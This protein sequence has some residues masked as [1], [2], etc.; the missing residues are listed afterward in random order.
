MNSGGGLR[1][2]FRE[3]RR[4]VSTFLMLPKVEIVE[5]LGAAGFDA[6]IIDLEHGAI[7]PVDL[8]VL[9]AVARGA[10][11][12]SIARLAEGTPAAVGLALDCGVDAVMVPHIASPSDAEEAVRSA[13]F[14]PEGDRSLNPYTRGN[15][16]GVGEGATLEVLNQRAAVVAMVEGAAALE[17][18][19]S[20]LGVEG[21]DAIFVG[22]MDLSGALGH[23]G[24]PDHPEVIATIE[25]IFG[26]VAQSGRAAGLYVSNPEGAAHWLDLGASFV[27]VSADIAMA[28]SAFEVTRRQVG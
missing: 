6:V 10:G 26:H 16:Y 12:A 24:Q 15:R 19:D 21:V 3:R 7:S 17:Q 9:A 18:L 14:A 8:P 28:Y 11:V 27:A 23:P 20:I 1:A 2:W 22:P 5:M 25:M 4:V 13:R